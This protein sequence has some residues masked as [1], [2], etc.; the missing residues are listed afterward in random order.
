MLHKRQ[1]G[2][3]ETAGA[4]ISCPTLACHGGGSVQF[5]CWNVLRDRDVRVVREKL[6]IGKAA[7]IQG[8]IEIEQL[9]GS[10]F[11]PQ[12]DHARFPKGI[13]VAQFHPEWRRPMNHSFYFADCVVHFSVKRARRKD[14][15]MCAGLRVRSQLK[16]EIIEK[17]SQRI[18]EIRYQ[19]EMTYGLLPA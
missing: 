18:G 1:H 10:G 16:P 12:I 6:G 19:R 5:L 2:N 17:P 7:P 14:R 3:N 15:D 9:P 4:A 8:P 11:E 13:D